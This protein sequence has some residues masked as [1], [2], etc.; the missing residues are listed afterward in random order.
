MAAMLRFRMS[1]IRRVFLDMDGVIANCN[2]SAARVYGVG[3]PATDVLGYDWVTRTY[4]AQHPDA[5][6]Q[7]SDF[8]RIVAKDPTFWSA[9]PWFPWAAQIVEFLQ[10]RCPDRWYFLTKSTQYPECAAGKVQKIIEKFGVEMTKKLVIVYDDK[11]IVCRPGD[12]LID[13]WVKNT[14]AWTAAGG[15]PYL[16]REIGD[17]HP[18]AQM[19]VQECLR[20]VQTLIDV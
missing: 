17:Q 2:K 6:V 1:N 13:D 20:F 5:P 18:E 3:Y 12:I 4:N 15:V 9:M 11:S 16:W 7:G 14:D 10:A 19:Q 8:A